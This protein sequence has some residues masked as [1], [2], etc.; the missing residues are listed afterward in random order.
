M[1]RKKSRYKQGKFKPTNPGKYIGDPTNIIYR[2]GWELKMLKMLDTSDSVKAYASEEI[3]I[4]Y[5]SPIDNKVHR[6]FVDML[7]VSQSNQVTLIEIKPDAQTR[8]PRASK[9]KERLIQES[10]TYLVN[11]AKWKAAEAY[12]QKKG[13]LFKVVTEKTLN[14]T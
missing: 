10:M 8:P 11:Q 2:S 12:C 5:I 7:V 3:V 6:Y 9:N 13:W 1:A 14:F 4:P